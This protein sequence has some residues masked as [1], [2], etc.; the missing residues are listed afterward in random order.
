MAGI[1]SSMPIGAEPLGGGRFRLRVWA[2]K[3]DK[4]LAQMNGRDVPLEAE[5]GGYHSAT[6]KAAPGDRYGFR[7][8]GRVLPDPASRYQP[9]GPHGLSSFV[10]PSAFQWTDQSWR[11]LQL[12]GQ[13]I[14]EMH[15]GTF[16][17]EG[18]WAAAAEKLP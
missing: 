6:V 8:G 13:V 2:P 3:F 12:C 14:S 18:T 9:D 16:T 17:P 10:D 11:G 1:H 5:A 4:L 15:V 7:V